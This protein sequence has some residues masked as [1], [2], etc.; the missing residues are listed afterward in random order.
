MSGSRTDI[1]VLPVCPPS[2]WGLIGNRLLTAPHD[3]LGDRG[4]QVPL[5]EILV[6]AII[7]F[8]AVGQ[9]KDISPRFWEH[10]DYHPVT[11]MVSVV[12]RVR[13]IGDVHADPI[14]SADPLRLL[15]HV[16]A[17]ARYADYLCVTLRFVELITNR[18]L[19]HQPQ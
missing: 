18:Y 3:S 15:R 16:S 4:P 2:Y 5:G 14:T 11:S 17:L 13:F 10:G 12:L 8:D 7:E 6:A 9:L 1:V 19:V